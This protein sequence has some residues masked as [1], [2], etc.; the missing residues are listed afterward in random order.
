MKRVALLLVAAAFAIAARGGEPKPVPRMQA[1]P[2]PS[3]QV[4]FQR[5]GEEITRYYA[6]AEFKRSF[7][8]PVIGPS[9]RSLTRMGHPHDPVT[10]S[11]HNSVWIAHQNVDGANFWE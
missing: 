1:I 6:G 9:G 7:L 8:F 3:S 4:S 2:L 10:H 11:H 5:D